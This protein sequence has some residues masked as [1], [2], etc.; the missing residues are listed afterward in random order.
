MAYYFIWNTKIIKSDLF[1]ENEWTKLKTYKK[2]EKC[3]QTEFFNISEQN[4]TR[5]QTEAINVNKHFLLKQILEV[6]I[7][8]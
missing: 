8:D 1:T 2:L 3:K 5:I 6:N 7:I 4:P